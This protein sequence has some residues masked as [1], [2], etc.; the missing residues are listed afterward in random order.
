MTLTQ[1][2]N[3]VCA[4]G[5][6][7][8]LECDASFVAAAGCA[9]GTLF[10]ELGVRGQRRVLVH[11]TAPVSRIPLIRH[12]GGESLTLPISGKAFSLWAKGRGEL[13]LTDEVGTR[14][15]RFNTEGQMIKS[16]VT[17]DG[18]LTLSGDYYYTVHDFS[19]YAELYGDGEDSIPSGSGVRIL[20]GKSIAEDFGGFCDEVR[21]MDGRPIT[22]ARLRDGCV[23]L[24][25]DYEGEI[26]ISYLRTPEA[27]DID[28]PDADIDL[29]DELSVLLPLATAAILCLD[30]NEDKSEFY[31][32]LY[33]RLCA[34]IK[35]QRRGTRTRE[36]FTNGWA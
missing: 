19:V 11:S 18:T 14:S 26:V 9:L 7:N 8:Y 32:R 28:N 4:L 33:Q 31:Y 5:F 16:A 30:G 25:E 10:S 12:R 35:E 24:P 36:Y 21:D 20:E 29:P 17:G 23:I 34:A 13:L 3:E 6:D 2:H 27:I 1:L 22:V 15:F